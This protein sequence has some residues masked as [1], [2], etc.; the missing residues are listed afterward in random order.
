MVYL[1]GMPDEGHDQL[2][3]DF[4]K[5]YQEVLVPLKDVLTKVEQPE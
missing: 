1:S 2:H 3:K 4:A 5:K